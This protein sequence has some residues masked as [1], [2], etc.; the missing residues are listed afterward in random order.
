MFSALVVGDLILDTLVLPKGQTRLDTDNHSAITTNLGGSAANFATWLASLNAE[1]HL[2]ARV[3]KG[4]AKSL[5]AQLLERQVIAHLQE[6]RALPTGRIVVLVEGENRTFYTDR[7]ANQNLQT[8]VIPA[9]ALGDLLYI[10]GYAVLDLGTEGTQRLISI[11]KQNGMVVMCD[12]GSAGFIADYGVSYFLEA[13]AGID[14]LIPNQAEAQLLSGK[15]SFIDAAEELHKLFSLVVITMAERGAYVR[16]AT[17][18]ELVAAQPTELVDP[19]GA[20]DAFAAMFI[21]TLLDGQSATV[22]A[23]EANLFAAQAIQLLGATPK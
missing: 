22:A 16:N 1:T 19:T 4:D 9:E 14:F 7:G 18:A 21:R 17:T 23:A 10:S 11:A 13:I 5:T 2:L 12:P 8:G 20:G 6:D 15:E 3:G